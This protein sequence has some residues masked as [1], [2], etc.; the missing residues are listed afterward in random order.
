MPEGFR[1]SIS[2][3]K[4][5]SSCYQARLFSG[6]TKMQAVQLS[7]IA[8]PNWI[9]ELA[10]TGVAIT[11]SFIPPA[12]VSALRVEAEAYHQDERLARAGV[13]RI[14]DHQVDLSIR[15]D[16]T[17]WMSRE[18]S[19]TQAW[20]LSEMEALRLLLNREL[21]LGLFSFEAHYAAYEKGGFY[22]RHLDAFRGA[23]NRILSTVLYLNEDWDEADG[24][25]L[26]IFDEEAPD[27]APPTLLV[28][29]HA[30]TM[31]IFLS[32]DIPHE[33][34]PTQKTRY[35]IAGWYRLNDRLGAPS[36]QAVTPVSNL[37][38]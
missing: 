24:G 19:E 9:A 6:F 22:A 2:L 21:F 4:H 1:T 35:S 23:R 17:R 26:A 8:T 14:G 10:A 25:E 13:G 34:L 7:D 33:V 16:K 31:T 15:R 12:L 30:G 3:V 20:Y 38:S 5:V 11:H 36:L 29:P 18:Q 37:A 27:D 32:E 28:P